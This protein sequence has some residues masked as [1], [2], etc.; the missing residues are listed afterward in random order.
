MIYCDKADF[1][2]TIK[3]CPIC[4]GDVHLHFGDKDEDGFW[5]FCHC[6]I[7]REYFSDKEWEKM[8]GYNK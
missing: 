6:H 4:G 8:K 5:L 7:C 1:E 3:K 2:G